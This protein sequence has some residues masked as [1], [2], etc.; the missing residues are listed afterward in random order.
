MTTE[1]Y[2]DDLKGSDSLGNGSQDN[3]YKTLEYFCKNIALKTNGDYIVYLEK[4]TYEITSNNIFGQFVSGNLT[5]I[6]L[7]EKTEILQKTGMYTNSVGGYANFTLNIARCR[8][9]ILTDL[10]SAN[11]MGFNWKWNFYNVLFEY[12]PNNGYSV[13]SSSTSMTIRNCVKLTNTTCFLR[14]NSSTISVYDSM[15]YFTSGY[16]TNQ[17]DWDKGGNTIGSIDN[18]EI[19]L[20]EGLYKWNIEKSFI[21]HDGVYKKFNPEIKGVSETENAIPTMTSD[22]TPFGRVN[23]SGVS[24]SFYAWCAFNKNINEIGWISSSAKSWIQYQFEEPKIII[25]YSITNASSASTVS[26]AT[27]APKSWTFEG[28]NDDL[29]WDILDTQTDQ[30][31]WGSSQ[32][33]AFS[34]VNT[35]PYLIYRLNIITNNG[36]SDTAVNEIEMFEPSSDRVAPHWSTVSTTLPNSTQFSEQGMNSLHSLNRRATLLEPLPMKD[37]SEILGTGAVG[38]VFSKTIDL[39]KF[40][41]I[42]SI[43]AEVK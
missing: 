20:K 7:R 42:R 43:R 3:P 13:F 30:I 38:N 33:R 29:T 10:T 18:Y 6:G 37:E 26:Y 19:V 31:S 5:I 4:G 27:R 12:T 35:K 17:S 16:S 34:I 9:N 40:F 2:I 11:L 28:S 23:S 41:D 36:S 14:K 15:G 39:E 22:I 25:K 1:I 32:K 24:S 8:Y 21:L